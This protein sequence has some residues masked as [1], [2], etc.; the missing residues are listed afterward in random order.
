[1]KGAREAVDVLRGR[2]EAAK[3]FD[4]IFLANVPAERLTALG[5]RLQ[6]DNGKL[7][8]LEDVRPAGA[9]TAS[10]R[11]R[12]EHASAN[13]SI[14][15]ASQAPFKVSGYWI[16]PTIPAGDGVEKLQADFAALPGRSGFARL[17]RL[18]PAVHA[19]GIIFGIAAPVAIELGTMA[20]FQS[21]AHQSMT[22]AEAAQ[23]TSDQGKRDIP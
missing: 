1:M 15:L 10:F 19:A 5:K 4:A 12:F 11:L 8:A 16:R 23:S 17:P 22:S 6:A 2:R 3:T 20:Y 18:T 21:V 7:V 13:G 9:R 14:T